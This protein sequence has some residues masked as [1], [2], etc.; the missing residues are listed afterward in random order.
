MRKIKNMGAST[1]QFKE[2]M[3]ITGSAHQNDG[4][5]SAFSLIVSGSVK[6]EGSLSDGAGNAYSTGGGGASKHYATGHCDLAPENKPVNWINASSISSAQQIKSW[7][8]VPF[9]ATLDKIIVSVNANNFNTSNDGNITLRVYKNQSN[10]GAAII[11][12][13]VGADDF[14]EK[15]SNMGGS[16]KD[17]NQK[18]FSGLNQSLAE[19]DLLQVKLE[20]P[21][22]GTYESLVTII[23]EG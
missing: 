9:A 23:F 17:C 11:D 21:S 18:I 2:G 8:I 1:V 12:Q 5:D 3:Y 6:I 19:G 14:T 22:S 10:F 7:F 13:T 4:T 15:V 20:K 16:S